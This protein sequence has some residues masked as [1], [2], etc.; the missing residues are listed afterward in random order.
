MLT[1]SAHWTELEFWRWPIVGAYVGLVLLIGVYGLHRYFLVFTYR[2]Y[3]DNLPR[4]QGRYEELPRVTVQL[5]TFNEGMVA[6]RIIDATCCIEY[7]ADRLQIQVVDDSTDESAQICEDRVK[8]WQAKGVDIEYIHRTDRTG[9]KA[10][11]LANAM[12]TAT[13]EFIAI[14]DADFVPPVTFLKRTIHHF[15]NPKLGMVQTRWD[16]LNRNDSLLTQ[17]QAIFLDGHF[18]IEHTAR[19]R[20][21][22]WF[23]F[24]G[25]GGVWRAKAIEE[26]GGWSHDTLTEDMDLSYRAQL[27]GWDFLFLPKV[28][29]PAE[30]PP[31]MN[32]FKS[33][34]HRWTK[35]SIQVAKKLLPRLLM[36]KAPRKI[37]TEA[38]FHLT[39][40][41][42]YLYINIFVLL[43]YPAIALNLKGLGGESGSSAHPRPLPVPD[44]TGAA[45]NAVEG[46]AGAAAVVAS[47]PTIHPPV[48]EVLPSVLAPENSMSATWLSILFGLSLFAMG[49]MSASVFYVTSQRILKRS[50][51]MTMLQIPMLMAVG[52]G[53]ALNNAIACLEAIFGHESEFVRTPKYNIVNK[54]PKHH[55]GEKKHKPAPKAKF[56]SVI[57]IPSL[58]KWTVLIELAFGFYMLA[59]TAFALQHG[60]RAAVCVPFLLIFATGYLYVGFSSAWIHIRTALEARRHRQAA[61]AI[62]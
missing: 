18:V 33:Q 5:P 52:I 46:V 45:G 50:I 17:S 55:A 58:K 11:A 4:P 2:K 16:H 36:S 1:L 22:R 14:F 12:K 57:P 34:Q 28:T 23:N 47:E 41:L 43:F 6:E 24:S 21:G 20:S 32:A 37:K 3:R 29:C 26:A 53:I 59:C 27:A 7:P 39:S 54:K 56:A 62:A 60:W 9:Y 15:T 31:E 35:G 30:L 25:T 40:P 19:C 49:A 42:V 48:T 51:W 61:A 10:G 38:F 13:G 8:H 44:V